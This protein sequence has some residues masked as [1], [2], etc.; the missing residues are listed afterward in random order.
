MFLSTQQ[1]IQ[2]RTFNT[3][4]MLLTQS[5]MVKLLIAVS[6]INDYTYYLPIIVPKHIQDNDYTYYLLI[7]VPKH[8]QDNDYTYYLPIIVP[9]NSQTSLM[10]QT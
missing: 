9:K 8:I 5:V 10:H 3:A 4:H 1:G 2:Q 6:T 7:I